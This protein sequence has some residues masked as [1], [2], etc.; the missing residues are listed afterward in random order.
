MQEYNFYKQLRVVWSDDDTR[1]LDGVSE[2][3]LKEKF[4]RY[5]HRG[6][7]GPCRWDD[8]V[9]K[10]IGEKR[11]AGI[12]FDFTGKECNTYAK[13]NHGAALQEDARLFVIL[14]MEK[15]GTRELEDLWK[16][17]KK[18]LKLTAF[19]QHPEHVMENEML[20]QPRNC[21]ELMDFFRIFQP[22]G[23]NEIIRNLEE[24]MEKHLFPNI[25]LLKIHYQAMF[26][27]EKAL[28]DLKEKKNTP[29]AGR[30]L[31]YMHTMRCIP[32]KTSEFCALV[33]TSVEKR[34]KNAYLYDPQGILRH[35][36]FPAGLELE[37]GEAVKADITPSGLVNDLEK[38][39][40]AVSGSYYCIRTDEQLAERYG[41]RC[42]TDENRLQEGELIRLALPMIR[43]LSI[44]VGMAHTDHP[45]LFLKTA[46]LPVTL[47][48]KEWQIHT[49]KALLAEKLEH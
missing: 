27:L 13:F 28:Q 33:G 22:Y 25:G 41:K 49:E 35:M 46:K 38:V 23:Y 12:C 17:T 19:G 14:G 29:E 4:L 45:E 31:A 16:K 6:Y 40:H 8:R 43:L 10:I 5:R 11:T 15:Y 36:P 9:W 26:R 30:I 20:M 21:P 24:Y 3:E 39:Y 47:E 42:L 34:E 1:I 7:I 44:I 18:V 2:R 48:A 37:L 32:I